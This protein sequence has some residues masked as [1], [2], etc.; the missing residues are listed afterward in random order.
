MIC[1]LKKHVKVW[2]LEGPT[3]QPES[4]NV[5]LFHH[6]FP[7][8]S[9]YLQIKDAILRKI[10]DHRGSGSSFILITRPARLSGLT[11]LL[12]WLVYVFHEM[13]LP[14]LK[15]IY[16]SKTIKFDLSDFRGKKTLLLVDSD[17]S[18]EVPL[19]FTPTCIVRLASEKDTH[20][21]DK[22]RISSQLN[23]NDFTIVINYL[24]KL[25]PESLFALRDYEAKSKYHHHSCRNFLLAISTAMRNEA[26]LSVKELVIDEIKLLSP[27]LRKVL[28]TLAFRRFFLTGD[29]WR[30]EI[31]LYPSE[32]NQFNK[33]CRPGSLLTIHNKKYC[34]WH[35]DIAEAILNQLK[36]LN[37][38]NVERL[39]G[40][41]RKTQKLSDFVK[42]Q[43]SLVSQKG[44]F[45]SYLVKIA[46]TIDG[47]VVTVLDSAHSYFLGKR[48]KRV[49]DYINYG[50]LQ[51]RLEEYSD[52]VHTMSQNNLN[53]PLALSN[54]ARALSFVNPDKSQVQ[55]Q[56]VINM[57]ENT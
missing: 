28:T 21:N 19:P 36:Y 22:I 49:Y 29:L 27:R 43:T 31:Q 13:N 38:E 6:S 51:I 48:E 37:L 34:V 40:L 56:K 52:A 20:R 35:H 42:F 44:F 47:G 46:K 55:F 8:L 15:V 18:L 5:Y 33:L 32:E 9:A 53:N 54:Y 4:P 23:E 57:T 17:C 39:F 3:L 14:D 2:L 12:R 41:C 10:R 7:I 26:V 11:T 16:L 45:Y 1:K 30:Y 25:F 50:R 24:I